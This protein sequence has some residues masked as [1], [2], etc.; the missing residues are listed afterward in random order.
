M[1]NHWKLIQINGKRVKINVYLWKSSKI[2]DNDWKTKKIHE[3]ST[4]IVDMGLEICDPGCP[5]RGTSPSNLG[6]AQRDEAVGRG[7]GRV[8][9]SQ[10]LG[11]KGFVTRDLHALRLRASAD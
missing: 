9:P 11:D 2:D 10:G 1:I 6:T 4:K 5:K 7:R 8:N 3:K